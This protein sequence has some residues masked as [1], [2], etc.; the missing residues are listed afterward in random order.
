MSVSLSEAVPAGTGA[1][2]P[3]APPEVRFDG[4]AMLM[5]GW[6]A[7]IDL[8]VRWLNQALRNQLDRLGL[9]PVVERIDEGGMSLSDFLDSILDS[10]NFQQASSEH[11]RF[12]T[13]LERSLRAL[14]KAVEEGDPCGEAPGPTRFYDCELFPTIQC[15]ND[16]SSVIAGV[17]AIKPDGFLLLSPNP[18]DRVDVVVVC[19]IALDGDRWRVTGYQGQLQ[20]AWLRLEFVIREG[21]KSGSVA[22]MG[23]NMSHNI[24][25]HV[26][27]WL[28]QDESHLAEQVSTGRIGEQR[29]AEERARF[30]KYLRERMEL[31]AGFATGVALS[32]TSEWLS[33]L[34]AGFHIQQVLRT[35]LGRSEQVTDVKVWYPQGEQ[36]DY[37]VAVPGGVVGIQAFYSILE[38]IVRDS[39]KYGTK[40]DLLE[41]RIRAERVPSQTDGGYIR[42]TASDNQGTYHKAVG[43]IRKYLDTLKI[44]DEAGR[45]ELEGWG[46]KERLIAAAYLRGLRL[47]RDVCLSDGS[48]ELVLG[49]AAPEGLKLLNIEDDDGNLSW[50]FHLPLAQDLLVVEDGVDGPLERPDGAVVAVQDFAWLE[51]ALHKPASMRHRMVIVRPRSKADLDW[52]AERSA[53]LPL[54]TYLALDEFASVPEALR[55]FVPLRHVPMPLHAVS[56]P[57][58]HTARLQHLEDLPQGASPHLPT[59]IVQDGNFYQFDFLPDAG[60]VVRREHEISTRAD[61]NAFMRAALSAG[62]PVIFLDAHGAYSFHAPKSLHY[63]VHDN[64]TTARMLA[65]DLVRMR[66]EDPRLLE[67]CLGLA[68]AAMTNI[69]IVDE[70]LDERADKQR[71]KGGAGSLKELCAYK[72]I[73]IRGGEY[74]AKEISKD[75]LLSW[76]RDPELLWSEFEMQSP[77]T[78]KKFDI[79]FLHRGITDK[80]E[81]TCG[82]EL[83]ALCDELA[84]HVRFIVLH[85]GRMD[86]ANIPDTCRFLPLSNVTEWVTNQQDKLGIVRELLQLRRPSHGN[87]VHRREY[88]AS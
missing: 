62:K 21:T 53:A 65:H 43:P 9:T 49:N 6:A 30:H 37:K 56:S 8:R 3:A 77:S 55:R 42:V 36:D 29:S 34:V 78:Q 85:S 14:V 33:Q 79:L 22:L 52:L 32:A 16:R 81:S 48:N 12:G 18:R 15:S 45:L 5:Y 27:F 74:A 87:A 70:R 44:V 11:Q 38:N 10:G 2:A 40:P 63:E 50:V 80:L 88:E 82:E 26:L 46:T 39:A 66:P 86:V 19:H 64:G 41:I 51:E 61:G 83:H 59:I 35:R 25:S 47:E 7:D 69:L 76:V 4:N 31:M 13:H 24:G 28:E 57:F 67:T 58:L 17:R 75:K 68:V 23:R 20:D 84:Q 71:H 72:G 60:E 54:G 1:I 73:A